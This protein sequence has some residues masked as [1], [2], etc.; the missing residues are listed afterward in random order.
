MPCAYSAWSS[1][2]LATDVAKRLMCSVRVEGPTTE[3]RSQTRQKHEA[4]LK[5]GG[6]VCEV[7]KVVGGASPAITSPAAVRGC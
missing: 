4:S 1:A 7:P 6:L 3:R 2:G 5:G